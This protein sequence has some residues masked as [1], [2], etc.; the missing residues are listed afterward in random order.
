MKTTRFLSRSD[1]PPL[2]YESSLSA[3]TRLGWRHGVRLSKLVSLCSMHE[4]KDTKRLPDKLPEGYVEHYHSIREWLSKMSAER[5]FLSM[6][7]G[8]YG[9]Y[10]WRENNFRFCPICLEACYHSFLFQWRRLEV[11]PLHNCVL[12]TTCLNCGQMVKDVGSNANI[13]LIGYRCAYCREPIAGAP[14][15]LGVHMQLRSEAEHLAEVMSVPAHHCETL[16]K[17][18]EFL[19]SPHQL[20]AS[21]VKGSLTQWDSIDHILHAAEEAVATGAL[22]KGVTQALGMSFLLWRVSNDEVN[23]AK[24]NTNLWRDSRAKNFANLSRTYAATRRRLGQWIFAGKSLEG[25]DR[26]LRALLD[27]SGDNLCVGSWDRLELTYLIFRISMERGD[28]KS[29]TDIMLPTLRSTPKNLGLWGGFTTRISLIAFRAWLLGA[30]AIIY[31]YLG[32]RGHM[33]IDEALM[34]PGFPEALIPSFVNWTESS[35]YFRGGVYFPTIDGMPLWPFKQS[36][37]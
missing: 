35:S 6:N 28:L 15:S 10:K 20:F 24:L 14:P 32:L 18:L 23:L 21:Q 36:R 7:T 29:V 33:T 17:G 25:E 1:L 5:D 11:C 16:Y 19:F 9:S 34:V 27:A 31:A 37:Q 4:N 2:P 30:F 26:R 22:Q 13:G 3:M 12:V 8:E